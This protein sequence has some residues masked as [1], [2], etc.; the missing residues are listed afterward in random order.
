[1]NTLNFTVSQFV[2]FLR[3]HLRTTVG[4][5]VVQGEVTGYRERGDNLVFFDIKDE[6]SAVTCFLMKYEL[7]VPLEDGMEVKILAIP[8][9]FKKSGKFHLKVREITPVG[10][11]ALRKA[12]LKLM[13]K[14]EKEGLLVEERKRPLPRFPERIGLITSKDAAAYN[15]VLKT[16]KRRWK[17]HVVVFAPVRVQGVGS[18][19]DIVQALGALNAYGHVETI[20][21]T[22]GGGSLEDLQSF[23]TE[24][25][26]RAI[27]AS[28]APVIAGVGHERDITIAELVADLRASTPTAAAEHVAPDR[29]EVALTVEEFS[30][31]AAAAVEG[32]VIDARD[33]IRDAMDRF[34]SALRA[35][36][37]V[38]E[39]LLQRFRTI[40]VRVLTAPRE[41]RIQVSNLILRLT[42]GATLWAHRQRD[43][44]QHQSTLL[45]SL[46][47]T[48]VLQRGYSVTFDASGKVLHDASSAKPKDRIRTRL[49]KGELTSEVL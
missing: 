22:R 3:E 26:A 12:F 6:L 32:Q 41:R 7:T 9:L 19:R 28:R 47:P 49:R 35:R 29:R 44:L 11:G 27:V 4:E 40:F 20:I 39:N 1:M 31:R 17:S 8:S 42:T 2:D 38:V 48:A 46:N 37:L 21:V 15:D 30:R 18:S 13:E 36:T 16:L 33:H 10:E 23:N 45:A 34:E 14:L 5:V 43:R 25:V 24:E